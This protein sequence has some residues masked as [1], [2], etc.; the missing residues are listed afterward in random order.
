MGAPGSHQ[1]RR[2][3]HRRAR[4]TGIVRDGSRTL[5]KGQRVIFKPGVE[6]DTGK[7]QA[8]DVRSAADDRGEVAQ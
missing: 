4:W 5:S 7:R 6:P 1:R 3:L 8:Y 2:R